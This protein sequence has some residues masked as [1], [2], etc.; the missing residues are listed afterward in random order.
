MLV[1]R[2][3]S[4]HP[5]GVSAVSLRLRQPFVEPKKCGL[6][7]VPHLKA[8]PPSPSSLLYHRRPHPAFPAL[9]SVP[10]ANVGP[11]IIEGYDPGQH[12]S[13]T[14]VPALLPHDLSGPGW[15]F[16]PRNRQFTPSCWFPR[17]TWRL[18]GS[19]PAPA[20][21]VLSFG[22]EMVRGTARSG[23]SACRGSGRT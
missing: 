4:V 1:G 17:H 6:G 10:H 19:L 9:L 16:R 13:P 12:P 20:D 7:A 14:A 21:G 15:I 23:R 5:V 11:H 2:Q 8:H 22:D 18:P 3:P